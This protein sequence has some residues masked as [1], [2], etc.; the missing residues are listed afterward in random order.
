MDIS[1][2]QAKLNTEIRFHNYKQALP[3]AYALRLELELLENPT[4]KQIAQLETVNL[5]IR[6]LERANEDFI[7]KLLRILYR[8]LVDQ[9]TEEPLPP[10]REEADVAAQAAT[11]EES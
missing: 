9:T 4:E 3:L 7:T 6:Q 10:L 5:R 11:K 8:K 2:R 1:E